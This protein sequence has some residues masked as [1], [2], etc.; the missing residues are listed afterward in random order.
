[1][2]DNRPQSLL[3]G[4]RNGG[5]DLFGV[6]GMK[7][8]RRGVPVGPCFDDPELRVQTLGGGL[9]L[10]RPRP[11]PAPVAACGF[12]AAEPYAHGAFDEDAAA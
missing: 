3:V 6:G 11:R 2:I 10:S 4:G 12:E 8:V 1:M 5:G 9:G 7:R